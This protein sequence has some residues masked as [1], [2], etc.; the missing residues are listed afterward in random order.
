MPVTILNPMSTE[1]QRIVDAFIKA[2]NTGMFAVR[3]G[4]QLA[5][6][7]QAALLTV[8]ELMPIW[9]IIPKDFQN[10]PDVTGKERAYGA[11]EDAVACLRDVANDNYAFSSINQAVNELWAGAMNYADASIQEANPDAD[12]HSVRIESIDKI[13][14]RLDRSF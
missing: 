14:P 10:G 1:N 8:I 9:N 2:H 4:Q 7:A 13:L 3:S 12:K 5:G 11:L 6:I